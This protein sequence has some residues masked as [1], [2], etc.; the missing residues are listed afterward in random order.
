MPLPPHTGTQYN[1]LSTLTTSCQDNY[2]LVGSARRD[3]GDDGVWSGTLASCAPASCDLVTC[4]RYNRC[5]TKEGVASCAPFGRFEFEE[6]LSACFQEIKYEDDCDREI[7]EIRGLLEPEAFLESF[8]SSILSVELI[9]NTQPY[10][11]IRKFIRETSPREGSLTESFMGRVIEIIEH[12]I[13]HIE[14]LVIHDNREVLVAQSMFLVNTNIRNIQRRK[15][16]EAAPRS[17]E[18]ARQAWL[19]TSKKYRSNPGKKKTETLAY[20]GKYSD[21]MVKLVE[22]AQKLVNILGASKKDEL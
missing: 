13:E 18:Q 1:T 4:P 10:F 21:I 12:Y 17:R 9:D 14:T 16:E 6:F 3:C 11:M 2:T 22:L 19:N 8:A 20:S 15:T 7:S 5:D